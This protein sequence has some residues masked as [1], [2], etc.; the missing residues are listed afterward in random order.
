MRKTTQ[1]SSLCVLSGV[2]ADTRESLTG[3]A[4]VGGGW[5]QHGISDTSA[6]CPY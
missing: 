1:I 5:A 2:L 4:A 6:L 3:A